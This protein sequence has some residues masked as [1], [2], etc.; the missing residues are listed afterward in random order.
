[1]YELLKE[2][3]LSKAYKYKDP[4]EPKIETRINNAIIRAD[5]IEQIP[6]KDY[7]YNEQAKQTGEL[8]TKLTY[9]KKNIRVNPQ[10]VHLTKAERQFQKNLKP[11]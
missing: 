9:T 8:Q 2:I 5:L 6:N 3:E 7:Y 11:P 4:T 1:M 10:Q